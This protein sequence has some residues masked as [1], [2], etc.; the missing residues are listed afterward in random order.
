MNVRASN[1]LG[2][3]IERVLHFL[4]YEFRHSPIDIAGQLDKSS[5]DS[6]LLALPRQVKRIDGNAMPA[7]S[8]S[9]IERHEPKW[10]GSGCID[11][12]PNIYAHATT[13]K[14]ELIHQSDIDHAEGVLEQLHHLRQA[15]GTHRNNSFQRLVIEQGA[16]L[17][18]GG[19]D[20][21]DNLGDV[22]GLKF[23]VAWI[24]ALG[25]EAQEEIFPDGT[26]G[27]LQLGQNQLVCGARISRRFQHY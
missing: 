8:G 20:S 21:S 26:P 23:R 19:R 6:S 17:S 3:V 24:D 15:S 27:S 25:R 13:H 12:L 9:G 2:G 10:L 11:H 16:D 4:D 5:F 7:E 18:T 22:R 14:G 1:R